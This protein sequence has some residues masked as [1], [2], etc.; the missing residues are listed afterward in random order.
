[1]RWIYGLAILMLAASAWGAD[2]EAELAAMLAARP[3]ADTNGDGKLS[4]QEA[5]DYML[6]VRRKGR[7][8]S[9]T[10][11]G[12][13]SLIDS[14]EAHQ[15]GQLRY[16][17]MRPLALEQGKRYPLIVSLHGSGGTGDDN[18]SNLRI[19]NGFMARPAWRE[20]YPAYV[21]VPQHGPG[22][23][24]GAKPDVPEAATLYVRDVFPQ[25]FE[26]IDEM[27][28]ELPIDP[29]RIYALGASGG[30]A[31]TWNMLAAR[32]QMFAAGIPV[33]GR[34]NQKYAQTL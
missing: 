7:T 5:A 12:D 20:K 3:E 29:Q 13:K 22:E 21:L 26:L 24:F 17:L 11:I 28:A 25:I 4:E 2:V 1:M 30:G 18:V 33:C 32:P 8:N 10:G 19:W 15:R 16:R 6:R 9:G 31:G 23:I 14:Y 27:A 34:F